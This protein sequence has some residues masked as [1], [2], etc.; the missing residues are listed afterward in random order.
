M[1]SSFVHQKCFG[2]DTGLKHN[3][4]A[5]PT[6][7]RQRD[8]SQSFEDKYNFPGIVGALDGTHIPIVNCPGGQ[9]DYINRKGFASIQ[10]QLVVDDNLVIND[11]YTYLGWPGSTHDARVLRNCELFRKA[12]NGEKILNNH[13]ILGDGAYPLKPWLMTPFRDN[14]HLSPAQRRFNKAFPSAR[15]CVER[16]NAR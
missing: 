15:Q 12:E 14:G 16:A 10:L 8:I 6:Y 3:Y 7:E 4:I 5:W 13:Y 9:N 2:T 1:V 11:P